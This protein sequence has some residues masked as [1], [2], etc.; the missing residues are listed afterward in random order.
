VA[1]G[2]GGTPLASVLGVSDRDRGHGRV[3]LRRLPVSNVAGFGSPHATQAICSTR[4]VRQ[5]GSRTWRTVTVDPG[6]QPD[7]STS[8]P[9][10]SGRLSSRALGGQDQL[11]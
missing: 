11:H 9:C 4:Q 2:E 5:G 6:H 10:L 3:E 1:G 8:K 7:P